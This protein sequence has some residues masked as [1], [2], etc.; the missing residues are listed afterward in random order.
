MRYVGKRI[1][2]E[3]GYRIARKVLRQRQF[4]RENQALG[5]D[6]V[7][8]AFASEVAGCPAIVF[9]QPQHA[10]GNLLEQAHPTGEDFRRDLIRLIEA[11]E[12]KAIVRQPVGGARQWRRD[13]ALAIIGLIAMRQPEYALGIG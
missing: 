8:L 3:V 11:A 7:A 2:G 12:D 4:G 6:S 13:L 9:E 10:S 1:E 5:R